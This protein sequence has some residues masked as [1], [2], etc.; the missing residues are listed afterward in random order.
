MDVFALGAVLYEAATGR[1]AF[2]QETSSDEQEPPPADPAGYRQLGPPIPT[3]AELVPA[4]WPPLADSI[5]TMLRPDPRERPA[6]ASEVLDLLASTL[7]PDGEPLWPDWVNS[8][9]RTTA[10][11]RVSEETSGPAP[12]PGSV[13]EPAVRVEVIDTPEGFACLRSSWERVHHRDPNA[14]YFLSWRWMNQV[15]SAY[16]DGWIVVGVRVE[17]PEMP[18]VCFLPLRVRQRWSSSRR[19]VVTEMEPAGR[20]LWGQYSGFVCDPAHEQWALP[21]LADFLK[22]L[23]WTTLTLKHLREPVHRTG[24]F[25]DRFDEPGYTVRFS[26]SSINDGSVDGLVCPFVPL[27]ADF[28]TYLRSCV[29][30]NTRQKIRRY[31]RRV[32]ASDQLRVTIADRD[33]FGRDLD[34]LLALW[35]KKWAPRRGETTADAVTAKYREILRRSSALDAVLLTVLWRNG[36]PLGA[37][38]GIV[39]R[40]ASCLHFIVAGRDED[41]ADQ[42]IGTV[43]HAHSIKWAIENGLA[44]YDFCHG[45]EAYKYSFGAMDRVVQHLRISRRRA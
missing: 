25:L 3:V 42:F 2:G 33:T 44:T 9:H 35:R 29:S 4:L 30:R 15:F 22:G 45:N 36:K 21:A 10:M 11:C 14:G 6:T 34:V 16:P 32:D 5:D 7:P 39:D 8:L 19:R 28:E 31:S 1:L 37:L 41:A 17:G 23:P 26:S 18:Y 38:A 43:L 40:E 20:F 27:P 24:L 13:I 12:T